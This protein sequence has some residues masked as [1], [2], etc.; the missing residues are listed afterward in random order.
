MLVQLIYAAAGLLSYLAGSIPFGYLAVRLKTGKDVRT[1]GSGNIGATNVA[2]VLGIGWFVPVFAL[3]FLKGFA[4]VF[5]MAPWVAQRWPCPICPYLKVSLAVLCGMC[6]AAGHMWPVF[7]DFKG[8]KGVATTAG[9]LFALNWVAALIG[10][11]VWAL[12]FAS[13]RYVSLASIV[14]AAA[15]PVAHHFTEK[16]FRACWK[17]TWV[18]TIFLA[19]SAVL[20][21]W[22]HRDNL[23]RLLAGTEKK[24]G[25]KES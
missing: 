22:R 12:V 3:D 13:F 20:V 2:R 24:F 9:I 6:A 16:R 10:L 15:V 8:G 7:L 19:V 4:P 5:W 17:A 25:R 23:R 21:V 18:I 14:A 11:G 1:M